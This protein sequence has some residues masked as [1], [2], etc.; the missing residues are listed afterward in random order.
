MSKS[1]AQIKEEFGKADEKEREAL[2]SMYDADA[3]SGVQKLI[4]SYRKKE[5]ALR[6]ERE[7]LSLMKSYERKYKDAEMICGILYLNDSKKLS[8]SRREALYD[9]I[10]EKAVAVG[11]GM[12]SPARIDEINILQATYEAMRKAVE[13]LSVVPDLLLND[14][15]TIPEMPYRQVPIVKGDAKSVSIA[16]ASVIAK[17]TRDRLMMQYDKILPEYGFAQNKGYGSQSHIE[18]LKRV[19]A[20][21][22]HRRSFIKN[23]ISEE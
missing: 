7:R 8:A 23:F 2:Y 1:I 21:P 13:Q 15:V 4:A 17:V 12:A 19:G 9:E 14:A 11:V 22:I 16:A 20:S 3:R 6:L 10:M 18:A 5:E